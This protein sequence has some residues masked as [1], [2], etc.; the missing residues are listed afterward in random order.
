MLGKTQTSST[1]RRSSRSA[2][3]RRGELWWGSPRLPGGSGKR[4]PFLIV[5]DDAF[6]TNDRYPK[7]MVVHLTTVR[8]G[9]GPFAWEVE[10]PGGTAGLPRTSTIKCGEVYT[11]LKN[12]LSQLVGTLP[13]EAMHRVDRALAVA[14]SLRM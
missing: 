5:S 11:L 7:V 4:R 9:G 14:L 3:V 13:T 1:R 12:H 8:R 10:L 6:N 2:V